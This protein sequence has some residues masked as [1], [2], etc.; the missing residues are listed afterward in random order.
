MA[1]EPQDPDTLLLNFSLLIMELNDQQP[2]EELNQQVAEL[3][4]A[5]AQSENQRQ[6]LSQ[7]VSAFTQLT[8]TNRGANPAA[9]KP[10]TFSGRRKDARSWFYQIEEYFDT[11]NPDQT[12]LI[13]NA[14]SYFDGD[15]AEW[16]HTVRDRVHR[17]S[18]F[19]EAFQKRYFNANPEEEARYKL[20]ITKQGKFS[21]NGYVNSF[22]DCMVRLPDMNEGDRI[23]HFI[24]GLNPSIQES[25]SLHR[26]KTLEAAMELAFLAEKA[27]WQ[28]RH[29]HYYNSQSQSN[30]QN[31]ATPMEIG[32]INHHRYYQHKPKA[33]NKKHV[34]CYACGQFG[35][36]ANECHGATDGHAQEKKAAPRQQS[37]C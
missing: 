27:V 1:S 29:P 13:K 16:W 2:L 19:Q 25:V 33:K 36:Y 6:Q 21:V 35:H 31:T 7:L 32:S 34:R 30:H 26:P 17:W 8:N 14:A 20:D 18:E 3:R 24:T 4:N 28:A 23:H 15:A 5:L 12:A 9:R 11:N 10:S 22:T 37:N